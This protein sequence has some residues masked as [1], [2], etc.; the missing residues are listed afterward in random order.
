MLWDEAD[1]FEK[2]LAFCVM[3]KNKSGAKFTNSG[4]WGKWLVEQRSKWRNGEL[5]DA[6][7]EA[8]QKSGVCVSCSDHFKDR[9]R[10]V[11]EGHLATLADYQRDHGEGSYPPGYKTK[12]GK[13]LN[14]TL[15]QKFYLGTLPQERAAELHET[16]G[17]QFFH[18]VNIQAMQEVYELTNAEL[19]EQCGKANIAKNQSY[20]MMRR[21]LLEYICRP[22]VCMI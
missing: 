20:D 5:N 7:V 11:Y 10:Q 2:K 1:T 21:R 16:Y 12:L 14:D 4:P 3:L 18:P 17:L 6:Q 9:S 19:R 8:L 15:K 22:E 13:Y